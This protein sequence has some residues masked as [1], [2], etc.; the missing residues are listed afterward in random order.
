MLLLYYPLILFSI[1][2]YG[3]FFSKKVLLIN[4]KNLGYFGLI[5]IFFLIILSY[6]STQI[7]AHNYIFNTIIISIGL[8]LFYFFR[9]NIFF[10]KNDIKLLI[11]LLSISIFFILAGKNH[12]DFE[13]YH[14]PYTLI[15][16]EFPHPIGLG[17]LNHGFK[18]HSSLFLL[19]SFFS[20]PGAKFTLFH[21]SPSFIL[22]FFNYVILKNLLD[23]ELK[24]QNKFLTYYCLF[25]FI[26]VNIFFY[27]LSEHG[28][29]RS[30]M[31]LIILLVFHILYLINKKD[32]DTNS[33]IL[34]I[35]FILFSIIASFKAFYL[36]YIIV[37]LPLIPKILNDK[38]LIKSFFSINTLFCFLL[39]S[40]VL[41]T[42]ILNTGCFLFPEARTCFFNLS[43]SLDRELV[44]YLKLHYENWAKAGSG[45]G[46]S[47][48]DSEK[49]DYVSNLNWLGS[50]VEN[51]F[52]N[53][54]SDLILSL[55]LISVILFYI[56]RSNEKN[57]IK[58]RKYK[59]LYFLLLIILVLWFSLHPALRY[60]GYHL[61]FLIFFI[62]LSIILEKYNENN[63]R[64]KVKT[65]II[66]TI[67]IFIARNLERLHKEYKIYN[68]NPFIKLEYNL[69][70]SFFRYQNK[71][72]E[73]I[74][75]DKIKSIYKNRYILIYN[76]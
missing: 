42:N 36:I 14:F 47:I 43:W 2:G 70:D 41:F 63:F 69:K 3:A 58:N 12:D 59:F 7:F 65:I 67:I 52:F 26:F 61:F 19:S 16:T 51:Y 55:L 34:K 24:K 54:V 45:S 17:N 57:Y 64:Y 20:L 9:R 74:K 37:L 44:D 21:I 71:I 66:L 23:S 39:V 40:L 68:Y 22:V 13:Y 25:S 73:D 30:A 56:F 35:I 75:Q 18:T 29:D 46:Y 31:I 48:L 38:N 60:G 53:K 4:V 11:L 1:V 8:V 72:Y 49:V 6:L 33:E 28:T 5:G 27:R 32:K 10:E 50:W 15:L 76:K 62:P